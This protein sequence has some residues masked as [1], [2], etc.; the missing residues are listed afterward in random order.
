MIC[1]N[2]CSQSICDEAKSKKCHEYFENEEYL[3][4]IEIED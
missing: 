3:N 1:E 2:C 4:D